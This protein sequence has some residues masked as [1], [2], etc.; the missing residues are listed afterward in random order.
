MVHAVTCEI[1]FWHEELRD[2]A[3]DLVIDGG[4][5]VYE[6]ARVLDIPYRS[7][8]SSRT[9]NLHYWSTM[10]TGDNPAVAK[11]YERLAGDPDV[12]HLDAPYHSHMTLRS[13]FLRTITLRG[14]ITSILRAIFNQVLWTL[15]GEAK[16]RQYYLRSMIRF[17]MRRWQDYQSLKRQTTTSL[18]SLDGVPFVFF[19]LQTEPEVSMQWFSPE[20]FFQ[21]AA[22]AA[23]SRDLPAG[24]RLVIKD[25]YEALGRRPTD[26]YAQLAD[27]KNV[28]LLDPMELGLRVVEKAQAV[29]TICST[30][31]F[32]AAVMGKPV[33]VFGRHNIYDFLPHVHLVRDLGNLK[34][35]IAKL[36]S[37]DFDSK[38][39]RNDGK[40]FLAAVVDTSF[41]LQDYDY[42]DLKNFDPE[43]IEDALACLLESMGVQTAAA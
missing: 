20:F 9:K 31:G 28:T 21:H 3:I 40:R 1:E 27:L 37:E 6:T 26:F 10:C 43:V 29:A 33:I 25:T 16:A 41:D 19:P 13:K 22:I 4:R 14:V 5:V 42:I 36:L 30:V 15:R 23:L 7:L 39:A 2:R 11:A 24:V 12:D 35:T 8:V 18:E 38:A 32:E 34:E 17:H